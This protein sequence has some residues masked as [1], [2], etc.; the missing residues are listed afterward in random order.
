[1]T[2]PT[3]LASAR[4]PATGRFP[5][6]TPR[7]GR[8]SLTGPAEAQTMRRTPQPAARPWPRPV[9]NRA[10]ASAP[11]DCTYRVNVRPSFVKGVDEAVSCLGRP[12]ANATGGAVRSRAAGRTVVTTSP[13]PLPV[14]HQ[15]PG[16]AGA[17]R[18]RFHAGRIVGW[19]PRA[20][21]AGPAARACR[22]SARDARAGPLGRALP[23]EDA[24]GHGPV[25]ESTAS[26]WDTGATGTER[27]LP[28]LTNLD[29]RPQ[30]APLEDRARFSRGPRKRTVLQAASALNSLRTYVLTNGSAD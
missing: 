3:S 29:K 15:R 18:G 25:P 5:T 26:D 6:S 30:Q 17:R 14:G 12:A 23:Q 21:G 2:V 4:L 7:N 24:M 8:G 1:M 20:Q 16:S 13:A 27:R 9:G 19:L 10:S 28:T 11:R 22:L